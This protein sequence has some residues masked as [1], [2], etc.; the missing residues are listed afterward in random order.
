MVR[1]HDVAWPDGASAAPHGRLVL[2]LEAD[3][4]R[5]RIG[6]DYVHSLVDDHSRLAYSEPHPDEK[7]P[8]C[9]GGAHLAAVG[10]PGS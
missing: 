5:A 3:R 10:A 4:K 1:H 7:G 2:G 8:T 9:A 6:F